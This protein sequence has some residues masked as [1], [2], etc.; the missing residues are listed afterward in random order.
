MNNK[1][2]GLFSVMLI[3]LTATQL[4]HPDGTVNNK[5]SHNVNV[6]AYACGNSQNSTNTQVQVQAGTTT[7]ISC[8]CK[9]TTMTYSIEESIGSYTCATPGGILTIS[10]G[11]QQTQDQQN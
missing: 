2:V 7:N 11:N 6:V 5:S 4:I 3:T 8:P 9:P 10:G 1:K